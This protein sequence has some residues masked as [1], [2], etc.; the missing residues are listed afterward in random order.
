MD[1]SAWVVV[2][3][4]GSRE[5]RVTHHGGVAHTAF[6][7]THS[8]LSRP[9]IAVVVWA[10]GTIAGW[11]K[12][13]HQPARPFE[14]ISVEAKTPRARA[15]ALDLKP[16]NKLPP[17]PLDHPTRAAFTNITGPDIPQ[18]VPNVP[19]AQLN[20]DSSLS[21]LEPAEAA[22]RAP[23]QRHKS[24]YNP[25]PRDATLAD[26]EE[27]EDE[28]DDQ[29]PNDPLMVQMGPPWS[30]SHRNKL[31]S[32]R[33]GGVHK[34]EAPVL[35]ASNQQQPGAP[36]DEEEGEEEEDE[37]ETGACGTLFYDD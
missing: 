16:W 17:Y 13:T 21:A 14:N 4:S 20:P 26:E 1:R 3:Q 8:I 23:V 7:S 32:P 34:E 18:L 29:A 27:E 35:N 2:S 5:V 15:R 33:P 22:L 19:H 28:E 36:G 30:D 31:H 6:A 11:S 9:E 25:D 12:T 37:E 24:V 10:V